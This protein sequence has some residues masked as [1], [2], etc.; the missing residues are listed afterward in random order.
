LTDD[1]WI[2]KPEPES[3]DIDFETADK[4][5]R[6]YADRAEYISKEIITKEQD[7]DRAIRMI[8]RIKQK[9]RDMRKVGLE[10]EE[11]EFSSENIAFKILRRDGVLNNLT[12][13]KQQAYDAKMSLSEE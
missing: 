4:K 12:D 9:I 1:E 5:A 7:F 8:D 6:D 3:R 10:S 11:S 13:L 2:K